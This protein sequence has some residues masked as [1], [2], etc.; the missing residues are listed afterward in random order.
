MRA[1]FPP[2]LRRCR[3]C[4]GG[5]PAHSSLLPDYVRQDIV[6]PTSWLSPFPFPYSLQFLGIAADDDIADA[7]AGAADTNG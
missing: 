2:A 1:G 3:T 5:K 6:H 4:M 7:E